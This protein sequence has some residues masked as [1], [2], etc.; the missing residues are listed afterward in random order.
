VAST[1]RADDE[2]L[3]RDAIAAA[4]HIVERRNHGVQ[5]DPRRLLNLPEAV[6]RRVILHAIASVTTT[7]ASARAVDAVLEVAAGGRA[8]ADLSSLRVEPFGENVVLVPGRAPRESSPFRFELPVPGR[9]AARGWAIDA[10]Y[11]DRPQPQAHGR[12]VAQIDMTMLAMPLVVRSRRAGDRLRPVGLRGRKKVQDVLVDRKVARQVRD[13]IP[14]V[15]DA[16]DR[17]VWVAGH[18]LSEEFR[19]TARTTS[20]IILKFRRV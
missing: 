16:E 5:L 18:A 1:L 2:A 8:A 11:A 19:V 17:I 10:E 20:V 6:A 4:A 3:E 14:V 15:T 13:D 9:L 12:D 7:M